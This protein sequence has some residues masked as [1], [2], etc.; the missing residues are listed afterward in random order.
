MRQKSVFPGDGIGSSKAS[1]HAKYFIL[2]RTQAFIGS[3]NV[4]P[5]SIVENTEIGVVIDAPELALQLAEDFDEFVK[6]IA[7]QV[8]LKDGNIEWHGRKRD[9][10]LK[11]FLRR[12]PHL[13]LFSHSPNSRVFVTTTLYYCWY[14]GFF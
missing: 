10:T 5:R 13:A 12:R 7:F 14:H 3:L 11:V 8:K 6:E 2:D 1:L 4:D 9:G